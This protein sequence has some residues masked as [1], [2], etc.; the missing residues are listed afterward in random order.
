MMAFD[1]SS[2]KKSKWTHPKILLV[3]VYEIKES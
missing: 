3:P 2:N 1:L